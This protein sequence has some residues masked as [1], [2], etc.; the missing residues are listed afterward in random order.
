MKQTV[1]IAGCAYEIQIVPTIPCETHD[2]DG[3]VDVRQKVIVLANDSPVEQEA[4]L[5]HEII[6]A[7]FAQSGLTHLV[8]IELEEAI[9]TAMEET[10]W[11]AGYRR[12]N[13]NVRNATSKNN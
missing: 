5:L 4:I 2:V 10:L 7:T 8:S 6:H 11:N 9:A 13:R 1:E 3:E 12:V